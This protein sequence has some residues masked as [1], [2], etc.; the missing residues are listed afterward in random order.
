MKLLF[1][2]ERFC[3]IADPEAIVPTAL[4]VFPAMNRRI[5]AKHLGLRDNFWKV[6]LE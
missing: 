4:F 5:M 6:T 2:P 3:L 1:Y